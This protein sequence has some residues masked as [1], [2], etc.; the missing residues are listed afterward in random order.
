MPVS[1]AMGQRQEVRKHPSPRAERE[2]QPWR[3]EGGDW[4]MGCR[5]SALG[6]IPL[7]EDE[8]ESISECPTYCINAE[9]AQLR[10]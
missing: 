8:P 10:G 2:L 3:G 9:C 7:L 6:W 1:G 5:K 4:K